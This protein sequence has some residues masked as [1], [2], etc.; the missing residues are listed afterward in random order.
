MDL[1]PCLG[2]YLECVN[3]DGKTCSLWTVHSMAG[4][5]PYINHERELSS[6]CI[7]HCSWLWMCCD[8]LMR[9][10]SLDF[11]TVNCGSFKRPLLGYFI[12]GT[13]KK[14][15]LLL[16]HVFQGFHQIHG[17]RLLIIFH[18]YPFNASSICSAVSL[19]ILMGIIYASGLFSKCRFC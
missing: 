9:A 1:R 13:E 15:R 2:D 3:W 8:Q 5:L 14:Q 16:S 4:T 11:P 10:W 7:H 17:Y 12:T 6:L 19:V 18:H